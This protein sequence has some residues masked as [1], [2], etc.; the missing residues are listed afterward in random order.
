MPYSEDHSEISQTLGAWGSGH[1]PDGRE[2]TGELEMPADLWQKM[3]AG[4]ISPFEART[5][6]AAREPQQRAFN[7][8]LRAQAGFGMVADAEQALDPA[9][10]QPAVRDA[11]TGQFAD[12]N[13]AARAAKGV[14]VPGGMIPTA[15]PVKRS[16]GNDGIRAAYEAMVARR[17]A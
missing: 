13:E 14:E 3:M 2:R 4:K 8:R 11:G 7:D 16:D 9:A 12:L 5:E 10:G 15:R 6:W 1:N 17:N